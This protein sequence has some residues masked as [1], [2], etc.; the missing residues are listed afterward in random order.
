MIRKFVGGGFKIPCFY[1]KTFNIVYPQDSDYMH[2]LL[3]PNILSQRCSDVQLADSGPNT[4]GIN[5]MIKD[6]YTLLPFYF[7]VQLNSLTTEGYS[8]ASSY[9]QSFTFSFPLRISVL[10]AIGFCCGIHLLTMTLTSK[11]VAQTTFSPNVC[12]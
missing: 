11:H 6:W 1:Y 2:A 10:I 5:A 3:E 12:L 9:R 8:Q 7:I 4:T